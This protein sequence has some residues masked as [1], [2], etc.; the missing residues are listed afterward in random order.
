MTTMTDATASEAKP[1]ESQIRERRSA[2][3][4]VARDN[5]ASLLRSARR[6]CIGDDERAQDLVQDSL[7]RAYEAFL[8]GSYDGSNPSPWLKR[9]MTN[10]FINEY[11]R[12]KKWDAGVT[13]ETLTRSGE[14]GP[15]QTHARS[16]DLPGFDLLNST[17]DE[18]LER[19]LRSLSEPVRLCVILVDIEGLDYAEAARA[20]RI[21]I[22]T[23][24]SRLAR[25]RMQLHDLLRDYARR[26]GI[27]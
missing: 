22:G 14:A 6:L 10:L 20:L 19:A 24:R 15:P 5:Q 25:A 3:I 13:V 4:R 27:I 12:S 9:I 16:S 18:E 7:V 11:R 23:V 17:L 8:K 21:P 1:T 26:R 2:F